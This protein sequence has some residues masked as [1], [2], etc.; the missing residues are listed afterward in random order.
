MRK[1][2]LFYVSNNPPGAHSTPLYSS[3]EVTID[4][5]ICNLA[6]LERALFSRIGVHED[7]RELNRVVP[8]GW[9]YFDE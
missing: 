5:P 9:Q 7:W 3:V 6:D 2:L 4:F 8:I 1:V